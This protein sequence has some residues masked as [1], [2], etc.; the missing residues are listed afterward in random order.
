MILEHLEYETIP[1]SNNPIDEFWI[2][3]EGDPVF[4]TFARKGDRNAFVE[5]SVRDF[6]Q[7]L[8]VSKLKKILDI[9]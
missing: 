4:F 1:G 8:P 5:A 2:S 6:L 9:M 7:T 3:P